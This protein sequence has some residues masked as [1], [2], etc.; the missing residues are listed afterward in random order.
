MKNTSWSKDKVVSVINEFNDAIEN[1]REKASDFKHFDFVKSCLLY[2]K[3]AKMTDAWEIANDKI[4]S[5]ML[6]YFNKI[7]KSEKI[8]INT[9]GEKETVILRDAIRK[10]YDATLGKIPQKNINTDY[11]KRRYIINLAVYCI[12]NHDDIDISS[13]QEFFNLVDLLTET[14][15]VDN[16]SKKTS[17]PHKIWY[18]SQYCHFYIKGLK[19]LLDF[20]F[21]KEEI[22]L[23]SK[24]TCEFDN[25]DEAYL[26]YIAWD[27]KKANITLKNRT[28][29]INQLPSADCEKFDVYIDNNID[30]SQIDN[31][32]RKLKPSGIVVAGLS[33]S[34]IKGENCDARKLFDNQMVRCVMT[35]GVDKG[36]LK[37]GINENKNYYSVDFY[38]LEGEYYRYIMYDDIVKLNYSLDI[39][40]YRILE[41]IDEF[42]KITDAL[43]IGELLT[44]GIQFIIPY[45]KKKYKD[46]LERWLDGI[47]DWDAIKEQCKNYKDCSARIQVIEA[48]LYF[49]TCICDEEYL[50]DAKYQQFLNAIRI[51]D[52]IDNDTFQRYY[53]DII[54]RLCK[55]NI[56][57]FYMSQYQFIESQLKDVE[58]SKVVIRKD[59]F[60]KFL[61]PGEMSSRQIIS[62]GEYVLEW[63]NIL[64]PRALKAQN[65]EVGMFVD[66]DQLESSICTATQYII[67]NAYNKKFYEIHHN[68][69][70][71]TDVIIDIHNDIRGISYSFD[72]YENDDASILVELNP[73]G[74]MVNFVMKKDLENCQDIIEYYI[75]NNLIEKVI[76]LNNRYLLFISKDKKDDKV[77]LAKF[78][79]IDD[80]RWMESYPS[81]I[82]ELALQKDTQH[83]RILSNEDFAKNNYSLSTEHYFTTK[84]T[85][86]V[87]T[88]LQFIVSRHRGKYAL[89]NI[90][91]NVLMRIGTLYHQGDEDSFIKSFDARKLNEVYDSLKEYEEYLMDHYRECVD[92]IINIFG[93]E[94]ASYEFF[95]PEVAKLMVALQDSN[96]IQ[97]LYNP[98]AGPATFSCLLPVS[99]YYGNEINK[100]IHAL[101][102]FRLDAHGL[103]CQG[104]H[105]E[106]SVDFV[107]S[108][109]DKEK[110]DAILSIPPF[111]PKEEQSLYGFLFDECMS[112]LKKNG[113]MTIAVPAGFTFNHSSII[114]EI[115]KKLIE[116]KWIEKVIAL[117]KGSFQG[118]NVSTCLIQLSKK[119][120]REV[121]FCD[122]TQMVKR[123]RNQVEI[124]IDD[125][126]GAIKNIDADYCYRIPYSEIINNNYSINP[127]VYKPFPIQEG[128][129]T[130][131]LGDLLTHIQPDICSEGKGFVFSQDLLSSDIVDY[132]RTLSD[133]K[134]DSLNEVMVRVPGDALLLSSI[135][136]TLKPT[137]MEV[138]QD[139]SYYIDLSILAFRVDE[140]KV[141]PAYLC[142]ALTRP[143][144]LHQI[145]NY[146][147]GVLADISPKDLLNIRINLPELSVQRNTIDQIS[148]Q[149]YAE[150]KQELSEMYG[151]VY[152]EKEE[153]FKSLKHAM[154]KSVEGIS[155]AVDTL[156]NYFEKTNQLDTIVHPYQEPTLEEMLKLI[157]HSVRH[158]ADLLE[159]GA[160]FLDVSHYP[161]SSVS[162]VD[163]WNL[164]PT[165]AEKFSISKSEFLKES[166]AGITIR[167]NL[168]MFKILIDNIMSN[169]AKHAFSDHNPANNVRV[170]ISS[171]NEWVTLY[172]SNNGKP[173]P[174][175]VDIKKFT[176]RHWSAGEN[177]GSG[178]GGYD[179]QK[180]MTAFQGKFELIT[181]YT[182]FYPT[183]YVLKLPIE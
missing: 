126:V 73:G 72:S 37:I 155:S 53:L 115:R 172:I 54:E 130:F 36:W 38:S 153:E 110:Y 181:D 49:H 65:I 108:L 165:K 78:N 142:Y 141:L 44:S 31:I 164:I 22:S 96:K 12:L 101:G 133:L 55:N 171:D 136:G 114:M 178:I 131:K 103:D 100:S 15:D 94:D 163:I 56:S 125:I 75:T 175:D 63:S 9:E 91:L 170:E 7:T 2:L 111:M 46:L 76:S 116:N 89:I 117:P 4:G 42:I 123:N 98:F 70:W 71:M 52:S 43:P 139:T 83:V 147:T 34:I 17:S 182:N 154:G 59:K 177:R 29:L 39:D 10:I 13:E 169:A 158:I 151:A 149:R 176:K 69:D 11:C 82:E 28:V 167:S 74:T 159:H 68:D 21:L 180:I 121:L 106:D 145:D 104:Y 1:L 166:F 156:Y 60:A 62:T 138:G 137:F 160:D 152:T 173:F 40:K 150:K 162:L 109:P 93:S 3:Q 168:K 148:R 27:S 19:S 179:I 124:Q 5:S 16:N 18:F 6:A 57:D 32:M 80:E 132:H 47:N 140:N 66:N 119:S 183:C 26:F 25:L 33:E 23:E 95:Q 8:S 48:F 14:K 135:Q 77:V 50:S 128:M 127:I 122:A 118:T 51:I 64:N 92:A 90:L 35:N 97:K 81:M 146:R 102:L 67:L 120:N 157:R 45:F 129:T 85:T 61:Y 86:D 84:A 20:V 161:L 79:H 113:K 134:T 107:Q 174:K 30:Y 87:E 24:I 99:T 144:M 58:K 41:K 143:E 105:C 88:I 112:H